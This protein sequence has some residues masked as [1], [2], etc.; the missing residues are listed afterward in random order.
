MN[1]LRGFM[2][3]IGVIAASLVLS[4]AQRGV[5]IFILVLVVQ[6]IDAA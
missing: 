4:I 5:A 2:R 3:D 6:L 1:Q